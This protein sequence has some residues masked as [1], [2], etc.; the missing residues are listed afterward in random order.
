MTATVHEIKTLR[1]RYHVFRDRLHAGEVLGRMLASEYESGQGV[2][3]LAI[4]SGGVPVG[5]KVRETLGCPMGLMIVRKLQIP[6][7]T[8]A[9]FGAMTL[10]GSLFL[11]E[12]LLADLN[13]TPSQIEEESQRVRSELGERNLLLREGKAPQDVTGKT[14]ILVDDGLAS[15]YTMMASIFEAKKKRARHT[16]VAIPTA[17]LETI[18]KLES[19]VDAVYCP[20]IREGPQFSVAGAYKN[21]Y[22]LSHQEVMDLLAGQSVLRLR[23]ERGGFSNGKHGRKIGGTSRQ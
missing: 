12:G 6:G 22:D 19:G 18:H 2:I 9:G 8:E 3:V 13:L 4:P 20:N 10:D 17:P 14:V 16:V 15:G 7:N 5:L 1:N 23:G 21:W 11:N